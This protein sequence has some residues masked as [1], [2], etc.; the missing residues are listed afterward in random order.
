MSFNT[1]LSTDAGK[2][3]KLTE[4]GSKNVAIDLHG[5][6]IYTFSTDSSFE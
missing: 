5:E 2:T 3:W 6:L 1:Y 4:A